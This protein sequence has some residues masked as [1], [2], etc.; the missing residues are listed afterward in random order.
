MP[1][2]SPEDMVTLV[3]DQRH[4]GAGKPARRDG[5]GIPDQALTMEARGTGA[6]LGFETH[7]AL[8]IVD[9][10]NN[11]VA[12]ELAKFGSG[13]SLHAEPQALARLQSRLAGVDVTGGKLIVAVDQYACSDCIARLRYFARRAGLSGFE[14]WVPTRDEVSPKTA[15]RTA[16]TRPAKA[17]P[18]ATT[19]SYRSGARLAQGE[20][21]VSRPAATAKGWFPPL[22]GTLSNLGKSARAVRAAQSKWT[23]TLAALGKTRPSPVTFEAGG[24]P[25]E[26]VSARSVVIEPAAGPAGSG[27]VGARGFG[28][29]GGGRGG[30]GSRGG[31]GRGGGG[32]GYGAVALEVMYPD[33]AKQAKAE[34]RAAAVDEKLARYDGQIRDRVDKLKPDI[35][36]LQ[37]TKEPGQKVYMNVVYEVHHFEFSDDVYLKSV[38][39]TTLN[40]NHQTTYS[41]VLPEKGWATGWTYDVKRKVDQH[42]YSNEVSVYSA[43]ELE[44]F[45]TLSEEYQTLK[46]TLGMRG[47]DAA[48]AERLAKVRQEIADAF[49]A[50]VWVLS[51]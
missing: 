31:A 5:T 50:D 21:F 17:D 44:R 33:R 10:E 2:V 25:A 4:W 30:G 14:V 28:K 27:G 34:A 13:S 18:L 32:F 22:T 19:A 49:G 9:A 39:V 45:A 11:Q 3:V 37:L 36:R 43:V 26:P 24:T 48:L 1:A 51:L 12:L 20:S 41:T 6:G 8:Q 47:H 7:A 40:A 23:R 29:G 46:R 38:D 35:A 42:T 16:A 15:A